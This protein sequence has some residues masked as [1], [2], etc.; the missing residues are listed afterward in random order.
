MIVEY[1]RPKTIDE[2]LELISRSG[3]RTYPMGGGSILGQPSKEA[4]AVVDLQNLALN[5]IHDRGNFLELG[6]TVT[7]QAL[8]KV[9]GLQPALVQAARLE[10]AHN[11]RQVGTLAGTLVSANGRSPLTTAFLALDAAITLLP[12]DETQPLGE[13]LHLRSEILPGRLITLVT[14]PRNT[15][16]AYHAVSRT[17]ADQPI[18]CAAVARWPSGRT[19]V[20]LGGFGKAPLMA[21]D[22]TEDSGAEVAARDAYSHADDQWASAEYRRKMA[23]VLTRRCLEEVR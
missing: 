2:A 4:F 3:V 17:P 23:E 6:A 15:R 9:E 21:F 16:L 22:G 18:V 1:H 11:L 12:R 5:N 10:A 19:R 14:I 8:M 7:L 13:L 20:A